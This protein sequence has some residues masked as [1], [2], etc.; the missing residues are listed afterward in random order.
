[1]DGMRDSE[2]ESCISNLGLLEGEKVRLEYVCNRSAVAPPSVWRD[3]S[4]VDLKKGLLVFTNDN[5]IFMQQEGRWSSNY[6]QAI[7][8]PL[9]Q[10]IGIVSGGKLI[11][12]LRTTVGATGSQQ[13]EFRE[14]R[15]VTHRN[16]DIHGI[17]NEI[18]LLLMDVREERKREAQQAAS[19]EMAPKMVF[20]KYCGARNRVDQSKCTNCSALLT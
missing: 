17:R 15:A 5:M 12:H 4:Q 11:K 13:H 2:Y 14:F 9:E 18:E 6:A 16:K 1:M 19:G 10:V 7:R 8:I 3:E 20:C